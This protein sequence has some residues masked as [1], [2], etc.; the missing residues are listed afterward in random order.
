MTSK[1]TVADEFDK[2]CPNTSGGVLSRCDWTR[3]N[4]KSRT[5]T[6]VDCDVDKAKEDCRSLG[7][8]KGK[9]VCEFTSTTERKSVPCPNAT[10][11]ECKWSRSFPTSEICTV[12]PKKCSKEKAQRDCEK[13]G[14]SFK[15]D[16]FDYNCYLNSPSEQKINKTKYAACPTKPVGAKCEWQKFED[17]TCKANWVDGKCNEDIAKNECNEFGNWIT[18]D[19]S[20]KP[21]T[22]APK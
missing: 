19:T 22:C 15:Q 5:C 6:A 4:S 12:S 21:Y 20:K 13:I 3:K 7:K 1:N 14:F 18:V 10:D 11:T 16:D 8:W 17:A 2:R 9:N